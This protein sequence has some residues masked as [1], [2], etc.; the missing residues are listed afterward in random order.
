MKDGRTAREHVLAGYRRNPSE[1]A[2]ELASVTP[3]PV[4]VG[5]AMAVSAFE[6]LSAARGSGFNG[7][8]PIGLSDIDAYTRLVAPLTPRAVRLVLAMD[9]ASRNEAEHA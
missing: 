8:H 3:G 9:S 6:T 7:P 2:A 4:P 5:A 1:F